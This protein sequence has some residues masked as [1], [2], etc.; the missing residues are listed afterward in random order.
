MAKRHG[1]TDHIQGKL[2]RGG[3]K[4]QPH[5]VHA[6]SG[7]PLGVVHSGVQPRIY[8][9]NHGGTALPMGVLSGKKR[10]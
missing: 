7:R 8:T 4:S 10:K 1:G 6:G 3:L 5:P 9:G 2:N